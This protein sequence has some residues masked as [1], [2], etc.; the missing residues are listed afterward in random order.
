MRRKNYK[1]INVKGKTSKDKDKDSGVKTRSRSRGKKL[2]VEYDKSKKKLEKKELGT[3]KKGDWGFQDE[4]VGYEKD[5]VRKI[6][7]TKSTK[8][9]ERKEKFRSLAESYR[10]STKKNMS[11]AQRSLNEMAKQGIKSAAQ[12]EAFFGRK[13]INIGGISKKMYETLLSVKVEN[14]GNIRLTDTITNNP[15]YEYLFIDGFDTKA[16]TNDSLWLS[17]LY[18]RTVKTRLVN[19]DEYTKEF[20]ENCLIDKVEIVSNPLIFSIEDKISKGYYQDFSSNY[21]L[22]GCEL[23]SNEEKESLFSGQ[24]GTEFEFTYDNVKYSSQGNENSCVIFNSDEFDLGQLKEKL[25]NLKIFT[26]IGNY[27]LGLKKIEFKDISMRY[28]DCSVKP[29][30]FCPAFL[31]FPEPITFSFFMRLQ[32]DYNNLFSLLDKCYINKKEIFTTNDIFYWNT[33]Q[34]FFDFLFIYIL[35]SSIDV[36]GKKPLIEYYNIYDTYKKII[37]FWKQNQ[38][39]L[40]RICLDFYKAFTSKINVDKLNDIIT[41]LQRYIKLRNQL[42][43]DDS[44]AT[45]LNFFTSCPFCSGM[46]AAQF[47]P[48]CFDLPIYM[49]EVLDNFNGNKTENLI[50]DFKN[51]GY[52]IYSLGFNMENDNDTCFPYSVSR[53]A[54]LGDINNTFE[55]TPVVLNLIKLRKQKDRTEDDDGRIYDLMNKIRENKDVNRLYLLKNYIDNYARVH[56]E[57]LNDNEVVEIAENIIQNIEDKYIADLDSKIMR[58]VVKNQSVE[59]AMFNDIGT[60]ADEYISDFLNK[61]KNE[62]ADQQIQKIETVKKYNNIR[63][64]LSKSSIKN[65]G[66]NIRVVSGGRRDEM[67]EDDDKN[68]Y[69]YGEIAYKGKDMIN[70]SDERMNLWSNLLK[71]ILNGRIEPTTNELRFIADVI[72]Y[73]G[74]DRNINIDDMG[75]YIGKKGA[76]DFIDKFAAKVPIDAVPYIMYDYNINN[77]SSAKQYQSSDYAPYGISYTKEYIEARKKKGED[78]NLKSI[79]RKKRNGDLATT[80]ADTFGSGQK[81]VRNLEEAFSGQSQAKYVK[82]G[83]GGSTAARYVTKNK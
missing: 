42:T 17:L 37:G 19:E 35:T 40:Q 27:T 5:F 12:I 63:N 7:N 30:S 33:I 79:V 8:T 78:P 57:E 26:S 69:G 21:A 67:D 18:K 11:L 73:S 65:I 3:F 83:G 22:I 4:A 16:L 50:E 10:R 77:R 70:Y 64:Q 81:T 54:F 71:D 80:K 34:Q 23:L 62:L 72:Y 44:Y 46:I 41:K 15:L 76:R 38:L 32:I 9:D 51:L 53:A 29:E 28:V 68:P 48:Q 24:F 39:L 61:K 60:Y 20:Y 2:D 56:N 43:A 47:K 59:D 6:A 45:L 36:E 75:L 82:R 49:M 66:S 14:T 1:R 58:L 74:L 52:I 55:E 31:L 25:N 13:K